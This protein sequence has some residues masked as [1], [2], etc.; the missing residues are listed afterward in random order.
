MKVQSRQKSSIKSNSALDVRNNL[1][2]VEAVYNY[3]EDSTELIMENKLRFL[4]KIHLLDFLK[5]LSDLVQAEHSKVLEE[6][7]KE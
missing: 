2:K 4:P 7:N 1:Y 6:Y 3:E 5:D